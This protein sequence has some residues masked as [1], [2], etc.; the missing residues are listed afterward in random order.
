M[1]VHLGHTV[2]LLRHSCP[3]IT[4]ILYYSRPL[5]NTKTPPIPPKSPTSHLLL[6]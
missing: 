1:T 4:T 6:H 3:L 2:Y 5:T